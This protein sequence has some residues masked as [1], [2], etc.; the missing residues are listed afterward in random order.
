MSKRPLKEIPQET[1]AQT[2]RATDPG[3]SVWVSANAGSG[4]THVLSERVI[5]LLLGG[6]EPSAIVCL[7]Y[8]K[9][10]A[11][12]MKNRVFE[13]LAAW[14]S[15]SAE[16]L[17][18]AVER[19]DGRAPDAARLVMA[20]RLFARA[21]ETP[22]GLKIQTIHSFCQMI[23]GRFPLEANIAGHF[24]LIDDAL[25]AQI[26]K[27]ARRAVLQK[28]G[29]PESAEL[30][31][32]VRQIAGSLGEHALDTLLD[33]TLKSRSRPALAEFCRSVS[34][35][36]SSRARLFEFLA[37]E[38]G[39]TEAGIIAAAWPLQS[40]GPDLLRSMRDVAAASRF[41][42]QNQFADRLSAAL[43]QADP[44]RR[45]ECLK[46]LTLTA[47]GEQRKFSQILKGDLFVR[48]PNLD[49]I[50][51][52]L[53]DEI[54]GITDHLTRLKTARISVQGFTIADAALS[55]YAERKAR[56]A[57]LDH[58]DVID[59]TVKLLTQSGA[60]AWVQYKLDQGISH[61]LVDE[62]QDTGPEQ[63]KVINALAAEFFAGETARGGERTLFAVGDEKQSIYSFQ[64]A[65]PEIFASTGRK[66]RR[67]A[68]DSNRRFDEAK[69]NLSFRS[70]ADVLS[71]VD[72]VFAQAESQRGLT[73][74]GDYQE[75][76]PIRVHG[77]GR[78][79]LWPCVEPL[80]KEEI[81]ESWTQGQRHEMAPPARLAAAIAKSIS[82]WLKDGALNE[83]SGE[84]I[85]PKDI[86]ILVRKRGPFVHALSRELK[87]RGI[88]VSGAD[89]LTL[90][91]HIAVK[92]LLAIAR[93]CLLSED[94]LSL[95]SLLRSPL[96]AF[97][98]GELLELAAYREPGESL[99]DRMRRSAPSS[100][101][102]AERA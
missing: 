16:K 102:T 59:R 65:R 95:A 73:A 8:T 58:D 80:E 66:T 63:W 57:V 18:D 82:G 24:E 54:N 1:I 39:D 30:A 61:I 81:P 14:T 50:I 6:V 51:Q 53:A 96:F 77:P 99:Y 89:R 86:M 38:E 40:A 29:R 20:R 62:A 52:T 10:A 19:L 74:G 22:G 49:G 37:V 92:D 17:A 13:R 72:L 55:E 78:V 79:E 3:A 97:S 60:G 70:T 85:L 98:D 46:D 43:A 64:G 76:Q 9:A 7:T 88:A 93:V 84:K 83:A 26:I 91:D 67:T 56:R 5:R 36:G 68:L 31:Q 23:L 28:A 100:P 21:L 44:L 34:E 75:H 87:N 2:C 4:K 35:A 32:A 42:A 45:F 12:V 71:A 94:D 27:D 11:A 90:T 69:L 15:L 48:F 41:V 33:E 25:M 101:K 47:N